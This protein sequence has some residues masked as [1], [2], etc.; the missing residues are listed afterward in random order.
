MRWPNE[1]KSDGD[2]GLSP[3]DTSLDPYVALARYSFVNYTRLHVHVDIPEGV[4][5]PGE[6]MQRRAGVFVSLH[7]NGDLRGCIGTIAPTE[8][9]IAQEIISNAVSAC[10]RDP[11]FPAVE[12]AELP[13]ITC[14]VDVLGDTQPCA[15]EDLDP[16]RYGIIVANGWRRGLLLPNL[17]GVDT[18]QIQV[19]IARRKAGI[20]SDEPIELR[21]F[22]VVRHE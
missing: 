3:F 12:V 19:A 6:M 2:K 8:P 21:R 9:D 20:G 14:S 5:L 15:F 10:S 1:W 7:K 22:K 16:K 13:E 18:A 11:R 4:Q 17:E